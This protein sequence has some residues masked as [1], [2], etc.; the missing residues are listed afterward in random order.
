MG[1]EVPAEA[2]PIQGAPLTLQG[3][4]T[5]GESDPW[6]I[7]IP[8]HAQRK[9]SRDFVA[10][11]NLA[12][13]ILATLGLDG[14][15]YGS[16]VIQ[17][18][19]GGSLWLFDSAGWFMVQNQAGIEWS[20]QFCA[21]PKKVEHL[22]LNAKRLYDA[23]PATLPEMTRLGYKD[24]VAILNTPITSAP[25][26]ARWVDSIFNSCVPLPAVRHTGVLPKGD[27]RHHYPTPVTDIDLIKYDDFVLWVTDP[28]SG[29]T[30]AVVPTAARGK[31]VNKTRLVY[32]T[33]GT[34][35]D[36]EHLDAR[37]VG[38][39]V[40]FGANSPLTQQAY[41]LQGGS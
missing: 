10:A 31:G 24:G 41:Q 37:S 21:D 13:K 26:V 8:D 33:P 18:H 23:F 35:L 19:H 34:Q 40:E 36:K 9:E 25:D 2:G 27:G 22:R 1:V 28:A 20:A 11:K 14:Q 30:A 6:A 12:K 3:Q 32:A 38:K 4:H 7:N 15:F 16:A 39:P 17:M 5:E 29:T